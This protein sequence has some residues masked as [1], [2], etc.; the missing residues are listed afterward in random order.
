MFKERPPQ[1]SQG[2][3]R[4]IA[5]PPCELM[6]QKSRGHE[7]AVVFGNQSKGSRRSEVTQRWHRTI[8]RLHSWSGLHG[9][10]QILNS[11]A[12]SK[13]ACSVQAS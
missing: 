11:D 12:T 10:L 4:R 7:H 2:L 9:K 5:V 6:Y 8:R 3:R 13:G 1:E